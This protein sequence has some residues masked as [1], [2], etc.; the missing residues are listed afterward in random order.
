MSWAKASAWL[1]LWPRPFHGPVSFLVNKMTDAQLS[2]FPRISHRRGHDLP[3]FYNYNERPGRG[4]WGWGKESSTFA[5]LSSQ[6]PFPVRPLNTTV[7][8]QAG[9][10][11]ATMTSSLPHLRCWEVEGAVSNHGLL[12]SRY[13]YPSRKWHLELSRWTF[14]Q[15]PRS[16]SGNSTADVTKAHGRNP[17]EKYQQK[18]TIISWKKK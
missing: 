2:T 12:P 6:F 16:V 5:S 4:N 13:P 7:S 18:E 17:R 15:N 14:M 10:I 1:C 9:Y 3:N 8:L 11:Y